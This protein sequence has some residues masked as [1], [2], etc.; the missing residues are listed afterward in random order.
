[1]WGFMAPFLLFSLDP[2]DG[3]NIFEAPKADKSPCV[4]LDCFGNP[5]V[6]NGTPALV[7]HDCCDSLAS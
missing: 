1:M 6:S 7:W 4:Y 2:K 3:P 5:Q